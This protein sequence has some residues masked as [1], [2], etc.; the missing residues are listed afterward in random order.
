[1]AGGAARTWRVSKR[2]HPASTRSQVWASYREI[3]GLASLPTLPPSGAAPRHAGSFTLYSQP[4]DLR[5]G[6]VY[7]RMEHESPHIGA[8]PAHVVARYADGIRKMAIS[9][10]TGDI[11]RRHADGTESSV[12][13][14][15]VYNHHAGIKIAGRTTLTDDTAHGSEVSL[16]LGF[17]ERGHPTR[18][19]S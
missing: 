10:F 14:Y 15:D 6:E 11:I 19:A 16:P 5:Y 12:P 17:L 13:L 18:C 9:G 1:M 3:C 8:L 7:A 4:F 2:L